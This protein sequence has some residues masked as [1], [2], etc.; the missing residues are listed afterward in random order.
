MASRRR[1]P[2]CS[3]QACT[4][5]AWRSSGLGRY[6]R[7][8]WLSAHLTGRADVGRLL[9][10]AAQLFGAN[11][12]ADASIGVG[13]WRWGSVE[14]ALLDVSGHDTRQ[15]WTLDA[16]ASGPQ[17]I[18]LLGHPARQQTMARVAPQLAGERT[19]LCL[20][21]GLVVDPIIRQVVAESTSPPPA[22]WSAAAEFRDW[23]APRYW[24]ALH[25]SR[26]DLQTAF[27]D[28]EQRSGVGLPAL[29]PWRV[30]RRRRA[31]AARGTCQRGQAGRRRRPA[32]QRRCQPGRLLHPPIGA[33]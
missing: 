30:L 33:R 18:E 9:S 26:R 2:T 10:R 32:P 27:P 24:R 31:V 16:G 25:E 3:L 8:E 29:V 11:E 19:S 7:V 5:P 17:R 28:P 20:P 6:L 13:A 22:P 1:K 15:P 14:P 4:A 12:C 23:L 21:G